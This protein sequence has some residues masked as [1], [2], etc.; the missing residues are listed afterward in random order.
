MASALRF[1]SGPP[2]LGV[3]SN[4]SAS[5]PRSWGAY[6]LRFEVPDPLVPG[7]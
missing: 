7:P 6:R 5:Y 2:R 1:M 4:G 3:P